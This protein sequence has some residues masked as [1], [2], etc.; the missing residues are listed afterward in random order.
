[1][2]MTQPEIRAMLESLGVKSSDWQVAMIEW[3]QQRKE[4]A[5]PEV[6]QEFFHKDGSVCSD[7]DEC[8]TWE[9]ST[10]KLQAVCVQCPHLF[11]EH[12]RN[13]DGTGCRLCVCPRYDDTTDADTGS[14]M[15][16][17]HGKA[18]GAECIECGRTDRT[19][20]AAEVI[21][22]RQS[23]YG[24]VVDGMIRIAQ[25]WSAYLGK[26][27]LVEAHDVPMMMI[28]MKAVRYRQSP[29]Y[30]DHTDDIEG[31]LDIVRQVMGEDMIHARTVA[32]YIAQKWGDGE[33]FRV[34]GSA[35]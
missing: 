10:V 34:K 12:D 6:K 27:G 33:V 15:F 24:E 5:M 11:A 31:Y 13:P 19:D 22:G 8:D 7:V 25:M 16:C 29:D 14:A 1:M 18:W 9:H 4:Q 3:H 20:V 23:V 2:A 21:D 32:D 35:S 26:D 30:S 28:L 17:D